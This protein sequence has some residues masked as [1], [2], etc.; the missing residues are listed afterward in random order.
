M[1]SEEVRAVAGLEDDDA[2]AGVCEDI[3]DGDEGPN[4]AAAP[5]RDPKP[6]GGDIGPLSVME[7][8]D[9]GIAIRRAALAAPLV[10]DVGVDGLD[11][12]PFKLRLKP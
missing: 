6:A 2:F 8:D 11:S 1:A 3:P 5:P 9:A 4:Q 12:A 7:D 10:V